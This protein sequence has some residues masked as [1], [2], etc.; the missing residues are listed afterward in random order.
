MPVLTSAE[1]KQ[2][3]ADATQQASATLLPPFWDRISVM[4]ADD[5][6]RDI[7]NHFT[8]RGY[9]EQ[10]ILDW[11]ELPS[12]HRKQSLFWAFVYGAT[13]H[14]YTKEW[15]KEFDQRSTF[16]DMAIASDG[17]VIAGAGSPGFVEF[18]RFDTTDDAWTR[19]TQ[20]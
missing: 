18:G 2:A 20:L 8:S 11:E 13:L 9:T 17:G 14:S 19:D 10:Q 12:V 6:W 5:G 15:V 16:K 7:R 1:V 4:A 3:I